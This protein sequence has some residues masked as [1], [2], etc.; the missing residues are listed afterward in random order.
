M[1]AGSIE[2]E[3]RELT[4]EEAADILK[5]SVAHVVGLIDRGEI[6]CGDVEARQK[7]NA[8]DLLGYEQRDEA[9]RHKVVDEL[10]AEAEKH[11]L[12]Y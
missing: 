4:V 1:K 9:E 7:I 8:S 6:P 3:D 10:T 12:G 2:R 5:V 11:R